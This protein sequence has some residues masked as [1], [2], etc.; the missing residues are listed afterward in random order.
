MSQAVQDSLAQ[1][2]LLERL[3]DEVAS[4]NPEVDRDLLERAFA[5]ACQAHEGQQRRS[6]EDF[7]HHPLGVA[8]ILA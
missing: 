8:A 7:I 1:Q 5:F 6:G 4:Y 2:D 3:L